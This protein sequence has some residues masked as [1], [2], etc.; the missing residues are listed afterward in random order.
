MNIETQKKSPTLLL[1]Y[2][3]ELL[4]QILTAQKGIGDMQNKFDEA[5]IAW[6]KSIDNRVNQQI[7]YLKNINTVATILGI[8]LLLSICA[9]ALNILG[10]L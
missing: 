1:A 8:L 10:M 5:Q 9:G 6:L 4:E 7:G 2:Q 3:T